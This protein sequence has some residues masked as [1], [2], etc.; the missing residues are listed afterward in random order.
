MT[1]SEVAVTGSAAV[2]VPLER[3]G[4]Q[5]NAA[6]LTDAGGGR[7]LPEA[8]IE[9]LPSLVAGLMED[10]E[11]RRAMAGAA[12]ARAQPGAAGALADRVIGVLP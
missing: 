12:A 7:L 8:E 1:V 11:A 4:Q 10:G 6:A 5:W 9:R 3:V 2:F